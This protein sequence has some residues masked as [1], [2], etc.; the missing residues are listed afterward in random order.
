MVSC[1]SRNVV[2]VRIGG[3]CRQGC[4]AAAAAGQSATPPSNFQ[5]TGHAM[6]RQRCRA[7]G[8]HSSREHR[9]CSLSRSPRRSQAR[10]QCHTHSP[11]ASIAENQG[12]RRADILHAV[13][14]ASAGNGRG[15][16]DQPIRLAGR[17]ISGRA[18]RRRYESS[19]GPTPPARKTTSDKE[20]HQPS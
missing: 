7:H 20:S 6:E 8:E 3:H 14:S 11:A 16:G 10:H 18:A 19:P 13:S 1:Q 9:A 17:L 4:F 5:L 12:V 2:G 15:P